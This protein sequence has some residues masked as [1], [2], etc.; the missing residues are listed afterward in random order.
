MTAMLIQNKA[1]L[2]DHLD[3]I[4]EVR[5]VLIHGPHEKLLDYHNF[6]FCELVRTGMCGCIFICTKKITKHIIKNLTCISTM[7]IT[8]Y[9]I[10]FVDDL[11]LF[12]YFVVTYRLN[13][14]SDEMKIILSIRDVINHK[15]WQNIIQ[16]IEIING[17]QCNKIMLRQ[18][19][20]C[21]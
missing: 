4:D 10:I 5:Q 14:G 11:K 8:P 7:I 17:Y 2:K 16:K 19:N 6:S 1:H 21:N 15:A 13:I 18:Y 3:F 12:N 20:I 9:F